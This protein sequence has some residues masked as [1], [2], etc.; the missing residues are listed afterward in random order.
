MLCVFSTFHYFKVGMVNI[1]IRLIM[2]FAAEDGVQ[3]AKTKY[4]T[5]CG[6]DYE[7]LF[8]KFRLK[9]KKFGKITGSSRY[10]LNHIIYDYTVGFP[11]SSVGKES[12]CNAGDLG[13][14][15]GLGRSPGEGIGYP[16]QYSWASLVTQLIKNLPAMWET[17]LDPWV[18]E[19]P[20]ER[21]ETQITS[22][23]I[24]SVEEMNRFKGLDMVDRVPE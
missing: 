9:L 2:I 15:P 7:L 14:I 10:D 16:L 22:F 5:N 3:S 24:I 23:T 18:G 6:S 11:D 12:T 19:V 21:K 13:S 1:Q 17:L 8:A 20:W 4:G